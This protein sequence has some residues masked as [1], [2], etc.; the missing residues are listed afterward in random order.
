MVKTD[1]LSGQVRVVVK[2]DLAESISG[3]VSQGEVLE[4][5]ISKSITDGSGANQATVWLAG[6]FNA[7]CG[8]TTVSL[9]GADP[10]GAYGDDVPT[11]TVEGLKLRTLIIEN[12]DDSNHVHIKRG[13][14]GISGFITGSTDSIRL[15]AGGMFLIHYPSGAGHALNDT[16]D[17]ELLV[18][19]SSA[20]ELVPCKLTALIG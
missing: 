8:G 19:G 2:C 6:S 7:S 15:P 5:S 1:T 20:T 13:A 18:T 10:F 12:M 9:A 3:L 16:V 11:G 17:D 14:A 4:H